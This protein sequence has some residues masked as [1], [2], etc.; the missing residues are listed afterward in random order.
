MDFNCSAVLILFRK[1]I[2]E[3]MRGSSVFV[4]LTTEDTNVK[5]EIEEGMRKRRKKSF[6]N[7]KYSLD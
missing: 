2:P 7:F 3:F 1:K 5:K 6:R 4:N